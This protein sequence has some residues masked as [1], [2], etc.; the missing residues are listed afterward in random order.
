M[1]AALLHEDI[2]ITLFGLARQPYQRLACEINEIDRSGQG[3]GMRRMGGQHIALAVDQSIEERS[4]H[5]G[6]AVVCVHR[7]AVAGP[8]S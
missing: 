5:W 8:R 4:G 3:Q 1:Q 7:S 2:V 6:S